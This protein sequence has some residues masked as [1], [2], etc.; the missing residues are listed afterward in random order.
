M[1]NNVDDSVD[2]TENMNKIIRVQSLIRGFLARRK[3]KA[4]LVDYETSIKYFKDLESSETIDAQKKFDPNAPT[5]IKE[6]KYS[7]GAVYNGEWK[8]G[9]RHG[10]GVMMWTDGASYDGNWDLGQASGYGKFSHVSGDVYSGEWYRNK[11]NGKGSYLNSKGAK[12]DGYW[13]DDLQQGE[14]METWTEGAK[15]TG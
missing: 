8:G 7:T 1:S 9:L 13:K 15:Y 11:T 4:R 5:E 2:Q 10:K 6:Y 12:Y 3:F 14:G